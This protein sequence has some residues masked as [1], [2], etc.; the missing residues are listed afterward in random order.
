MK[1]QYLFKEAIIYKP[2]S[3][4]PWEW[5]TYVFLIRKVGIFTC[6]CLECHPC[7]VV[8]DEMQMENL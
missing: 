8:Y 2:H 5:M 4:S 7:L 3:K 6:I 1:K